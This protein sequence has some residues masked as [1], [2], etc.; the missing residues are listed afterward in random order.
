MTLRKEYALGH[1]R[2]NDFLFAVIGEE[3]NGQRLTVLS[4]L[5]RLGPNPWEEAARLAEMPR[6]A[7]AEALAAILARLPEDGWKKPG[8][9]AIAARLVDALPAQG[10]SAEARTQSDDAGRWS[11]APNVRSAL[12]WGCLAAAVTVMAIGH[13]NG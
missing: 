9:L 7:A 4:A 12:F 6:A 3:E 2:F 11:L 5:A 8:P 13:F 10:S 1:S